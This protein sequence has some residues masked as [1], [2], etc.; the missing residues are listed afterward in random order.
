MCALRALTPSLYTHWMSTDSPVLNASRF[1]GC[2]KTMSMPWHVYRAEGT[3]VRS[4][5]IGT[6]EDL[7]YARALAR[8]VGRVRECACQEHTEPITST[9]CGSEVSWR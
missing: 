7:D 1:A 5:A 3:S 8:V 4:G 9:T 2:V 6:G